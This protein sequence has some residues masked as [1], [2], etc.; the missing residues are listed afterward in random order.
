MGELLNKYNVGLGALKNS[1]R[2]KKLYSD[3]KSLQFKLPS[4]A[5][6]A[7]INDYFY[8]S[9]AYYGLLISTKPI[10]QLPS[11]TNVSIPTK[12]NAKAGQIRPIIEGQIANLISSIRESIVTY[13]ERGNQKAE[14]NKG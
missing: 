8:Q 6:S 10:I 11:G 12:I 3:I 14:V 2:Y 5:I 13:K 7:K 1:E 4:V 9:D